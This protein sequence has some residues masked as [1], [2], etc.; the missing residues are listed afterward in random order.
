[1]LFV[2]CVPVSH[3]EEGCEIGSEVI[4]VIP[5]TVEVEEK[6]LRVGDAVYGLAER[7]RPWLHRGLGYLRS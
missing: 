7:R 2:G 4:P 3:E 1:M 5:Q 6:A